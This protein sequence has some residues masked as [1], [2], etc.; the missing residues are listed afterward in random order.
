MLYSFDEHQLL[1]PIDGRDPAQAP[2]NF[3]PQYFG[4]FVSWQQGTAGVSCSYLL[5]LPLFTLLIFS[6]HYSYARLLSTRDQRTA[7]SN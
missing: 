5:L 4:R 3:L 7:N 1:F 2:I 6:I